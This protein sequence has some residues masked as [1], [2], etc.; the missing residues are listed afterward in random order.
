MIQ[1]S[2]AAYDVRNLATDD[3]VSKVSFFLCLHIACL[4]SS[5]AANWD[6][7]I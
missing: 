6:M 3:T 5:L 4:D 1:A 7:S 2:H